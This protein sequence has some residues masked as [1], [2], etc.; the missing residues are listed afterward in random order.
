MRKERFERE[1]GS[2]ERDFNLERC[3][4]FGGETGSATATATI[5]CS[6][7]KGF[8]LLFSSIWKKSDIRFLRH[9]KIG[10]PSLVGG[11]EFSNGYIEVCCNIVCAK[12]REGDQ[13]IVRLKEGDP[14]G[15][16]VMIVDRL[17]PLELKT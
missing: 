5:D 10:G 16:H 4:P 12:V 13:R 3:A 15:R 8:V 11:C 17:D 6:K 14:R 9:P 2:A 7:R 1:T